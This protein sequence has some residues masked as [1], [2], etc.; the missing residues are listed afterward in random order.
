[1]CGISG[2]IGRAD[3]TKKLY[4]SIRNLEYR[5]YDSCGIAVLSDGQIKIKKNIGAVDEVNQKEKF[6]ELSGKIGIAHTRWATH[7]GVSKENSH[8]HSSCNKEF[9]IVHNGIISNYRELKSELQKKG[10]KFLSETDTE[11]I[12]HEIEEFYSKFRDVEKAIRE[13]IKRLSGTYAFALI[14]VHSPETIYCARNESPLVLGVGMGDMFIGSDLN[15]FIEYTK[16]IVF[17]NDGEYAIV[18]KDNFQIKD[19]FTGKEKEREIKKIEWDAEMAKKGGYPHYMLKEIYEEPQTIINALNIEKESILTLAK[20]ILESEKTYFVGVGT[21]YYVALCAQ[22]YF[23]SLTGKYIPA[24]S[25][26]EFEY[27]AE[28]NEK[29]LIIAISQ[30]GETYDTL[31]ALR[32]SKSNKSKTSAIVNVVGSSMA[33]EV[34][35]SIMQDSGPEI[36]VLSTKAALSQIVI[37]IRIAIELQKIRKNISQKTYQIFHQELEEG[38]EIIRTILNEHSAIIKNIAYKHARVKNWLYLGRGIYSAIALES[39]LKMKEVTYNHAEGMSGG[40]MKHGTIA[41]IDK[42]INSLIFMPPKED[43]ALFSLTLGNV[44]E[45]KARTGFVLGLHFGDAKGIFDEEVILPKSP[46]LIAPLMQLIAG[47]LFA[48]FSATALKRNV[49]KPRSLAKSVTVA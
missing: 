3:I 27:I 25:S 16:N 15:A 46:H 31:R 35:H 47:Q 28:V 29:T 34:N 49:D 4:N 17:L 5:G 32:F 30:S 45:I 2:L 21:T 36:C 18:T 43:N 7:G 41:L 26:D 1:M 20:M 19:A 38:S 6:L 40:F 44:E 39:A 22:Y 23:S 11:V 14:S 10:H 42:D 12:V 13:T 33:R 24:I 8:P 48:Y 37:L 9:A